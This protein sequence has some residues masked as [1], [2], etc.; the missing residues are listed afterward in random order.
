VSNRIGSSLTQRG[1]RA[2]VQTLDVDFRRF[3]VWFAGRH[4]GC[5]KGFVWCSYG[6]VELQEGL[7]GEVFRVILLDLALAF[8]RAKYRRT[9]LKLQGGNISIRAL[10]DEV[11]IFR[12]SGR[13]ALLWG[14]FMRQN[15][16]RLI[17]DVSEA[18][19]GPVR[20]T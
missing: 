18:F 14:R 20:S 1:G 2:S 6:L 16:E 11:H 15:F 12:G 7:E 3:V 4:D 8:E 10:P 19:S 13:T 5:R 17:E 9:P